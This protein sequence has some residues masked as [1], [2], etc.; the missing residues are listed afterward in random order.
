LTVTAERLE[1][2]GDGKLEV[3][4]DGSVEA[5]LLMTAEGLAARTALLDQPLIREG[6]RQRVPSLKVGAVNSFPMRSFAEFYSSDSK[7]AFA[8]SGDVHT[9]L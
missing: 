5:G 7:R 4:G 8:F 2:G 9:F 3:R 1:V 6:K